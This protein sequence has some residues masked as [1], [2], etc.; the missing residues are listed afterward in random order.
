[1]TFCFIIRLYFRNHTFE[2]VCW[3]GIKE[4]VDLLLLWGFWYLGSFMLM[5]VAIVYFI[6]SNQ[7]PIIKQYHT[8]NTVQV[9]DPPKWVLV[10]R[11][12][13][14]RI[15]GC[16]VVNGTCPSCV[17]E[18]VWEWKYNRLYPLQIAVM[19]THFWVVE[20]FYKLLI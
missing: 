14:N 4:L 20:L 11:E 19:I 17:L 7:P 10:E 2:D 16:E 5:V 9:I 6:Q 18:K 3:R 12:V 1:M 15:S 13:C 8:H